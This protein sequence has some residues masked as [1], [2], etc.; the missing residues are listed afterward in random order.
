MSEEDNRRDLTDVHRGKLPLELMEHPLTTSSLSCHSKA[1]VPEDVE[2]QHNG[3][4]ATG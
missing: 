2:A 3:Q 1:R 4:W